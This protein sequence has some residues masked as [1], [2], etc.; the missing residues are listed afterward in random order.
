M[1][2][3]FAVA[4]LLALLFAAGW[5]FLPNREEEGA[6]PRDK[7]VYGPSLPILKE[8]ISI[9]T[10]NL[11]WFPGRKQSS[12]EDVELAHIESVATCLRRTD[13]DII[14]LQEVKGEHGL[15]QLLAALPG[16]KMQILSDF[17]GVQELAILSKAD[18]ITAFTEEFVQGEIDDPPRGFAHAA[19]DLDG[20]VLLVYS[21]HLK[22]NFGGIEKNIPV[23]EESVRQLLQH[24]NEMIALHEAEKP[25][26]ISVILGGDFNT[27]LIADSFSGERT[28]EMILN[29]GF[30]WGFQG[31][32]EEKTIT[33][34][35]D[36]RY[37]D[38]TFDHFF[39]Q[40]A[41]G[42]EIGRS[43]VLA[44]ERKVSDHRPVVM[45]IKFPTQSPEQL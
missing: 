14:C 31:L 5:H 35:S 44:T 43:E 18:A 22:S 41:D 37:P 3:S 39:V 6:T 15:N 2:R 28:A 33:W 19:F 4:L 11:Q 32:P 20:R 9:L 42:V 25:K 21:V 10:W 30:T 36:G 40:A 7:A 23:R 1:S 26:S 8:D 12:S 27:S 38:V 24:V 34:L 17:R 16:Y 45:S 29:T 13:A